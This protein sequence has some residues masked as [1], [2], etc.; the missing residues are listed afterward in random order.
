M[1]AL[2]IEY[3]ELYT[4]DKDSAVEYFVQS[5]GF[6]PVAESVPAGTGGLASV[7]LRC[8]AVHLVVTTG[9]GTHEFLA[10]HGDGIADIAFTCDDVEA[11]FNAAVAAGARPEEPRVVRG[12]GAVLHSLL[13][14]R[15]GSGVALPADRSWSPLPAMPGPAGGHINA[16]DHVAVCVESGTLEAYA[17][18]YDAGFGLTRYGGE[19]VDYGDHAM[20]S[21]VVRSSTG[22]ITFTLVASDPTKGA[23]QLDAFLDRNDGP[24]VQHLAFGVDEIVPA[25]EE[26][27]HRGVEFLHTPDSYYD[28]LAGRLSGLHEEIAGLRSAGVLADRDEWGYLFQLFTRSPYERNT[29]FYELIQRRGAHGFGSAN[30]R[31]LYEAVDRAERLAA[32]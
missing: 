7:A 1:V 29:L 20:D 22:G 31:A 16:L 13:P 8:G 25:V 6:S 12:F 14:D 3:A 4:N 30:I 9:P 10:A 27:R 21:I 24:G 26:F 5:L 17:D 19:Y 23:G 28:L 32:E 18:F 15:R 2:N 11:T